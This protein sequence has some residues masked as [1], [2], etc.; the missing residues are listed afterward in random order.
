MDGGAQLAGFWSPGIRLASR[1]VV[2]AFSIT[3]P[4]RVL[5]Y[6]GQRVGHQMA[7]IVLSLVAAVGILSAGVMAVLV[8][9]AMLQIWRPLPPD[10]PPPSSA[11]ERFRWCHAWVFNIFFWLLMVSFGLWVW[12]SKVAMLKPWVVA[13]PFVI[14]PWM[15]AA[16]MSVIC[17]AG[18]LWVITNSVREA[19]LARDG[20]PARGRVI[21]I[22]R[23]SR[24]LRGEVMYHV[25]YT[26]DA[27][28]QGWT[29]LLSSTRPK[30]WRFYD[31][32]PVE[33]RYDAARPQ[34]NTLFSI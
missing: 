23:D 21:Q 22:M 32:A 20:L 34:R 16:S 18:C 19:L 25:Q 33:V 9:P 13:G 7:P 5:W 6:A 12:L 15:A 31:G 28:G 8:M 24:T 27:N 4:A 1:C 3:R 2:T 29:G 26:F 14:A 10:P 30:N 11:G 17:G